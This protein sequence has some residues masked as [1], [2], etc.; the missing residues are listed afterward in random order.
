MV[1][2]VRSA[3]N[4]LAHRPDVGPPAKWISVLSRHHG[5]GQMSLTCRFKLPAER[6][7]D[8]YNVQLLT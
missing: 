2:Y 8:E 5:T 4:D 7:A 1:E 3:T 6:A